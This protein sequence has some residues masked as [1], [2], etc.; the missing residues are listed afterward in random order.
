MF[1][2]N[3]AETTIKIQEFVHFSVFGDMPQRVGFWEPSQL[4]DQRRKGLCQG[5]RGHDEHI[6]HAD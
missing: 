4:F 2:E 1:H 3:S 6:A 5:L